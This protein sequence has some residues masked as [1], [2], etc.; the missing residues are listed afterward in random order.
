MQP[1]SL[2][3]MTSARGNDCSQGFTIPGTGPI[4]WTIAEAG[5]A[6]AGVPRHVYKALLYSYAGDGSCFHELH[7]EL[8]AYAEARAAAEHW[9]KL[10]FPH[11]VAAVVLLEER[12]PWKFKVT[13]KRPDPRR[14]ALE[15]PFLMWRRCGSRA[16]ETVRALYVA[17]LNAGCEQMRN[18]L[19]ERDDVARGRILSS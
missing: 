14:E 4:K 12:W 8:Q 17:W 19:R 10:V 2:I 5:M 9:R 13:A 7:E 16:Y 1:E 11:R 18:F 6:C 15:I 3:T